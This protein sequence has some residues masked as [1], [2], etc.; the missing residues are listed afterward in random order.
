M[1]ITNICCIQNIFDSDLEL[2]KKPCCII[3][4]EIEQYADSSRY[5]NNKVLGAWTVV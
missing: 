1:K 5:I 3:N 4:R 2:L